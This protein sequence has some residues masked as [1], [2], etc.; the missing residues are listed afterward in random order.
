[1]AN[2]SV[3]FTK[4]ANGP[5]NFIISKFVSETVAS[6]AISSAS[7][8]EWN[9]ALITALGGGVWIAFTDDGTNPDP[10]VEG[11]RIPLPENTQIIVAI[12]RGTKVG[13]LDIS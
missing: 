12:K 6:G 9:Y 11:K 13:V 8:A 1:M 2:A 10:S 5:V 3:V 7:G 4:L